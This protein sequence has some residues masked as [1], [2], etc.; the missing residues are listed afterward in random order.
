MVQIRVPGRAREVVAV[1]AL[2]TISSLAYAAT[3]EKG[4]APLTA[5]RQSWFELIRRH[6]E[7]AARG[8]FDSFLLD[9]V[10]TPTER[11]IQ[12]ALEESSA[13][14]ELRPELKAYRDRFTRLLESYFKSAGLRRIGPTEKAPSVIVD[15]PLYET[16]MAAIGRNGLVGEVN[17]KDIL[18]FQVNSG[19]V[20]NASMWTGRSHGKSIMM[21]YDGLLDLMKSRME[22]KAVAGH[23]WTH[24][25]SDHAKMI[26]E[27]IIAYLYLGED[28]ID[29]ETER[30]RGELKS[31]PND[32]RR[33]EGRKVVDARD[34][35]LKQLYARAGRLRYDAHHFL[36]VT[37][38]DPLR[39]IELGTGPDK[40]TVSAAVEKAEMEY[41][42]RGV[43]RLREMAQ[44][45]GP[46]VIRED[47]A[48]V[49]SVLEESPERAEMLKAQ[50]ASRQ[51]SYLDFEE[52]IRKLL[53]AV[54]SAEATADHGE[55]VTAPVQTSQMVDYRLNGGNTSWRG[56]DVDRGAVEEWIEQGAK[57]RLEVSDDPAIMR[58]LEWGE[59]THPYGPDRARMKAVFANSD[60]YKTVADPFQRHIDFYV[61]RKGE[62]LD[63]KEDLEGFQR[64]EGSRL[65]RLDW[66][67]VTMR[68]QSAQQAEAV[69]AAAEDHV[70]RLLKTPGRGTG[71][72]AESNVFFEQLVETTDRAPYNVVEDLLIKVQEELLQA[73]Q[74]ETAEDRKKI[75]RERLAKLAELTEMSSS[76][77]RSNKLR[78]ARLQKIGEAIAKEIAKSERGRGRVSDDPV[79]DFACRVGKYGRF[80]AELG[81][82]Q[83][84]VFLRELSR[85]LG[86]GAWRNDPSVDIARLADDFLARQHLGEVQV[87]KIRRPLVSLLDW[88]RRVPRL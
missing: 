60:A 28:I 46:D 56:G 15:K 29:M 86:D 50:F 39:R 88:M 75:G 70:V 6:P 38:D 80:E 65:D 27:L 83:A 58:E 33:V 19:G 67:K 84:R 49:L 40:A 82:T 44:K 78:E 66:S 57:A 14:R 62:L 71:L 13:L 26:D 61:Q 68:M 30:G 3:P 25:A 42:Q 55:V 35:K 9:Q 1:A 20:A 51:A 76:N 21:I 45:F 73:V 37:S 72:T 31:I 23:E 48:T 12:S 7:L 54:R 41:L 64:Q 2:L 32:Q 18:I 77:F 11:A 59:G 5:A 22:V 17:P 69:L 81:S 85:T 87:A 36:P 47:L 10:R 52:L 24:Y 8:Y 4:L 16:V 63:L 74:K 53:Y 43:Q 34:A 79:V